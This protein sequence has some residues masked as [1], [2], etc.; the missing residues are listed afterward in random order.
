[1]YVADVLSLFFPFFFSVPCEF[2][3]IVLLLLLFV[4]CCCL[5]FSL[6]SILLLEWVRA[7][8]TVCNLACVTSLLSSEIFFFSAS[9][10]IYFSRMC[11]FCIC[12]HP[13]Y[14]RNIHGIRIDKSKK[15]VGIKCYSWH[16]CCCVGRKIYCTKYACECIEANVERHSFV[17]LLLRNIQHLQVH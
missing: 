14:P 17:L 3:F 16:F 9:L 1:M 11:I 15:N 4:S 13:E 6:L 5:L 8:F 7:N 2:Y 12:L 10:Y